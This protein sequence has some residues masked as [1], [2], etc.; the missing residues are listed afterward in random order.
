M[1]KSVK[2]KLINE[3]Y[4]YVKHKSGMDIY[5]FPKNFSVSYAVLAV[6]FGSVDNCFRLENDELFTTVPDGVAHFLEHKMFENKDGE[7]TFVKYSRTGADG[8]AYTSYRDTA[9]VFSCT[10]KLYESLEI[11]IKS[12]LEP[13]FTKETVIKEQGII[14]NEIRMGDDDPGDTLFRDILC[15]LYEN[16]SLKKDIAG[17]VNSINKITPEILYKCHSVFYNPSNMILCVCG[18]ADFDNVIKI[19]DKLLKNIEAHKIIRRREAE[20]PNAFKTFSERKMDIS[21]PLFCIGIKDTDISEDSNERTAKFAAFQIIS[22][23]YFGKSSDFYNTLYAKGLISPSFSCWS[24]HNKDF[25]FF[26]IS[27]DSNDPQAVFSEFCKYTDHVA[28]SEINCIDF[29]RCRRSCLAAFIRLF[30][31]TDDIANTLVTGFASD[32]E[33]IFEYGEILSNISAE[34]VKN[35]FNKTFIPSSFA[36]STIIPI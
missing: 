23:L 1:M 25:S 27:G 34:Y 2:S 35:V 3:Q 9:Y 33:N 5:V 8:N 19:A 20:A 21:K 11:L 12:T 7:D 17:T 16:S 15:C 36:L 10:E 6:K 22:S 18:Q 32:D 4:H 26:T 31:S 24:Q 29:E 28:R 14:A 30:D 13:Y